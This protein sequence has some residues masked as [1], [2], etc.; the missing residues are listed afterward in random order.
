DALEDAH[1]ERVHDAETR[2]EDRGRSERVE[3]PEDLA[4][5]IAD[6]AADRVDRRRLE[7]QLAGHGLE[8][9]PGRRR[10][11]RREP[12]RERIRTEDAEP[13]RVRPADEDGLAGSTRQPARDDPGDPQ[14]GGC[15]VAESET[16]RVAE[17]EAEP[18]GDAPWHEDRPAAVQAVQAGSAVA[19]VEVEPAVGEQV[20]A[21]DRRR[22]EADPL[23]RGAE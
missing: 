19:G 2:D 21:D 23:V 17:T 13:R 10:L 20:A 22:I 12:D 8:G 11:T 14:V 18:I 9:G 3:E 5:R 4:E 1:R 15:T 6:R 7:S 16:H